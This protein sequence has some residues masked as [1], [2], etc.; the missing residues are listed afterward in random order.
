MEDHKELFYMKLLEYEENLRK[1]YD[2]EKFVL[3]GLRY[4]AIL[5][6]F[7]KEKGHKTEEGE[8]F[9][10]WAKNNFRKTTIGVKDILIC[11]KSDCPVV[12]RDEVFNDIHK[13]H[14][15]ILVGIKLDMKLK[16]VML[17]SVFLL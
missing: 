4:E 5:N 12:T 3:S 17:E 11:L 6:C 1:H 13:C 16:K 2:K 15:N 8:K 9:K 7:D 14:L 10:H